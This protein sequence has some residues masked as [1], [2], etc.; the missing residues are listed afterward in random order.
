MIETIEAIIGLS[1]LEG[2]KLFARMQMNDIKAK[3]TA[4]G[5]HQIFDYTDSW[6]GQLAQNLIYAWLIQQGVD[7]QMD[8]AVGHADDYDL[9]F[10]GKTIDI[11]C[12]NAKE[13][14][15]PYRQVQMNYQQAQACHSDIILFCYINWAQDTL[16]IQG[17]VEAEKF[18]RYKPMECSNVPVI[19]SKWTTLKPVTQLFKLKG[20]ESHD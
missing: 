4:N 5:L 8:H 11:K 15:E 17:W 16:F 14:D 6:I 13:Q 20:G 7:V 10:E 1:I 3:A 19:R 12:A 2:D 18:K 9:L